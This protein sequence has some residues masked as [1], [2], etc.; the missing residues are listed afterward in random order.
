MDKNSDSDSKIKGRDIN[1]VMEIELESACIGCV[2]DIQY[3]KSI[4]CE[5][6]TGT[7]VEPKSEPL[8]CKSCDGS[9]NLLGFKCSAC[10]GEG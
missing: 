1:L 7:G 6:C 10:E 2:K 8:E 9:G 3:E 4:K 5:Y